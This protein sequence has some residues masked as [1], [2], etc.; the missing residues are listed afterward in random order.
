MNSSERMSLK[1]SAS[2]AD[3]DEPS[4][5]TMLRTT[6][7]VGVNGSNRAVKMYA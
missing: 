7:R 2:W 1:F 4:A 3:C 6:K 5:D